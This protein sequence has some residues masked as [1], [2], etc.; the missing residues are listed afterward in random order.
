[1][2]LIKKLINWIVYYTT[3]KPLC[4]VHIDSP[5]NNQ[6]RRQI[7]SNNRCKRLGVYNG[8]YL[9]SNPNLLT[10]KGRKFIKF[11]NNKQGVF[12]IRKSNS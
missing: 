4:Y 12:F 8:L 3:T 10:K 2:K 6:E 5:R 9:R 7:Q 11:S 1:M